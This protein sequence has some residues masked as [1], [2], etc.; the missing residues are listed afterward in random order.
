MEKEEKRVQIKSIEEYNREQEA[1]K[2]VEEEKKKVSA[3]V[4][5]AEKT[6]VMKDGLYVCANMGCNKTFDQKDN[7]DTACHHHTGTPYFHD[8]K[9]A[10]TCCKGDAVSEFQRSV[11][12]WTGTSS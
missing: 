6:P 3:P 4:A 5:P 7:T 2:K 1:K 10:W 11:H 9:K 8:G 12:S